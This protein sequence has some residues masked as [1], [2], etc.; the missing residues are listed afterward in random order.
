MKIKGRRTKKI[1]RIDKLFGIPC[2]GV[3]LE[4]QNCKQK[5]HNRLA[6]ALNFAYFLFSI[7]PYPPN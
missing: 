5:P 4:S 2:H 3:T 6:M 7:N 1:N